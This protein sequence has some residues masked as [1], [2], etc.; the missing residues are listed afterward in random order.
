[1]KPINPINNAIE[2][3][4]IWHV[5]SLSM[6]LGMRVALKN[7]AMTEAAILVTRKIIDFLGNCMM[8]GGLSAKN[9]QMWAEKVEVISRLSSYWIGMKVA[10]IGFTGIAPPTVALV[11]AFACGV[12]AIQLAFSSS[13]FSMI[14]RANTALISEEAY[15]KQFVISN[16][17]SASKDMVA[18]SIDE[19]TTLLLRKDLIDQING[20]LVTIKGTD[21]RMDD[22]DKVKALYKAFKT[23]CEPLGMTPELIASLMNLL[24]CDLQEE[25]VGFVT[26][27][28]AGVLSPSRCSYKVD[29]KAYKVEITFANFIHIQRC[30]QHAITEGKTTFSGQFY[31][32]HRIT[33]QPFGLE[34]ETRLQINRMISF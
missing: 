8:P 25:S 14:D 19:T 22:Q 29:P 20:L 7:V 26:S 24:P 34:F 21:L 28:L 1:M 4:P 31:V 15:S 3:A 9:Q 6:K 11:I 5:A 30:Y 33:P 12:I 18:V 17:V 32:M 2:L 13:S 10:Q 23:R 27:K 16:P